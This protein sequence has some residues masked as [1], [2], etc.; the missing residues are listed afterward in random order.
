M[1]TEIFVEKLLLKLRLTNEVTKK[2]L[3]DLR[4]S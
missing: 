2:L 1:K 4:K 3:K